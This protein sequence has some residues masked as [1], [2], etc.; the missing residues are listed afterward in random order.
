MPS[1]WKPLCDA[2]FH[3]RPECVELLLRAGA[4]PNQVAGTGSKHTPLT[5]IAQYHKTIPR[6]EGHLEAMELLLAHGA[7]PDFPAGPLGVAP[8]VYAA[9]GPT[10]SFIQLLREHRAGNTV[11][12]Q[13]ALNDIEK[14]EQTLDSRSSAS[15]VDS[16]GRTALHFV[17]L[18][19]MWRKNGS[20]DSIACAAALLDRGVEIDPVE[21]IPDGA[22]VF[23]ATPLWYAVA[24][25]ENIDLIE[26][27]LQRGAS[28]DPAAFA[29][30]Y[31]GDLK[32]VEL[33]HSYGADW[34]QTFN[35]CTPIMDLLS[36]RRPKLVPWL[37]EHGASLDI[38]NADGRTALHLAAQRGIKIEYIEALL[39][40][41][42]R[43][44]ATDNAGRTPL[45]LAHLN[46]K[47]KAGEFLERRR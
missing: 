23:Q 4:D 18:S 24:H 16:C 30:T 34:N 29:A 26:F 5:R 21:E 36:F 28:P 12:E 14:L 33:L 9:V 32:I 41:G 47:R 20:K 31:L 6:H 2:A 38:S 10:L 39:K 25:A 35:G 46:G 43:L 15:D 3:G 8:L 27:L 44:D 40:Y 37:L 45:D 7:R 22:E 42:A 13:A 17:G 1:H 19:G 11:F